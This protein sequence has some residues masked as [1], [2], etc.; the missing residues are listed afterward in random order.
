MNVVEFPQAERCPRGWQAS[1]VNAVVGAC[2]GSIAAGDASGYETGSTE[3][4]DPQ[5]YVIGPAPDY[6]CILCISRLGR[7]YVLEDGA[8]TVLFEHDSLTLLAQEVRVALRRRKADIVARMAVLWCGVRE[9]FEEKVEPMLA[10][11][12]EVLTH[13]APQLAALV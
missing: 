4:G 3:L 9:F 12:V 7:L 11:P 6:D 10:E 13:V 1:E 8:G 5:L 2:A